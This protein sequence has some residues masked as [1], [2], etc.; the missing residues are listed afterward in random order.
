MRKFMLSITLI[1]GICFLAA[2]TRYEVTVNGFRNMNEPIPPQATYAIFQ[3][4]GQQNDLAFQE[5]SKMVE[6]K[7]Q[8][9]GYRKTDIKSADLAIL[10]NYGIDEGVTSYS[11]SSTP[12]YGTSNFSGTA[13]SSTGGATFYTGQSSG[14]VSS[15]TQISSHTVHKRILTLQV[16]DLSKL[17]VDGSVVPLWKSETIS[18]GSSS[19][20]RRVV[21]YLIEG[22]FMHFGENTKMGIRH[23]IYEDDQAIEKLRTLTP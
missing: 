13:M 14:I 2:C 1:L 19:D 7:L 15:Q 8:E 4:D 18:R 20:L 22:T 5:Y 6:H 11:A 3:P 17:R 12:V 10:L 16:I 21:P 23:T 9:R